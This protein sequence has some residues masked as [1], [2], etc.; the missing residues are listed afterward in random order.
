M[1]TLPQKIHVGV[2]ARVSSDYLDQV[3]ALD[4]ERIEVTYLQPHLLEL[5]KGEWPARTV[6]RFLGGMIEE[7]L[8]A[9]ELDAL[10][11]RT[12]VLMLGNP[13]PKR[14]VGRMPE[15]IW[16]HFNFA[17]VSNLMGSDWY[18]AEGPMITSSRG[19]ISPRPIA[20][21]VIA[22]TMMFAR[23][24]DLAA[25]NT[26]PGFDMS[27]DPPALNVFG[28]TMGIIGMGG[29]G[30]EVA[31]MAKGLG[32]RVVATR[33]TVT[34]VQ[35]DVDGVDT[36]YPPSGLHEALAQSDFIAVCA[37][38]TPHTE[39]MLDEAAFAAVKQGA[40][41]LNIARDGLV[42]EPA[43]IAALESGRLAGAY[44]DVW[45]NDRTSPPAQ[46]LLDNPNVVCTPHISHRGDVAQNLGLQVFLNNLARLLK[47]EPLENVIDWSRGY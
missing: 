6:E 14:V 17:G 24:L 20:E 33:G 9:E 10:L 27:L 44:L 36:V 41:F 46:A 12:H 19:Y 37:M 45:A 15:L 28:K 1:P 38:W 7:P 32:M 16:G 2:A 8:P 4:P 22:A 13:F 42:V 25:R 18:G 21:S 40:F 43:L 34:E 30:R 3:R 23:R 29:I 35:H 47:G 31:T 11:G 39:G 5:L 26:K